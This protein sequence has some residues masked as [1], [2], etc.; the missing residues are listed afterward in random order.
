MGE[1]HTAHDVEMGLWELDRLS[2]DSEIT[3]LKYG[4][5]DVR[6]TCVSDWVCTGTSAWYR[7]KSVDSTGV[8]AEAR[9]VI[10]TTSGL[11][12]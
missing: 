8:T 5:I 9:I 7:Q 1:V 12:W 4:D 3:V 2:R 10:R 11:R 6:I